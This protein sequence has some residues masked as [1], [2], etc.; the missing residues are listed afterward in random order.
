MD[1]KDF[2]PNKDDI[3]VALVLRGVTEDGSDKELFNADGTPMTITVM[4]PYSKDFKKAVSELSDKRIQEAAKKKKTKVSMAEAEEIVIETLA[5]TTRSWN[6]TWG[7]EK[8]D[9][10][11]DLAKTIYEDAFWIRNLVEDARDKTLDFMK[12]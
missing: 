10:N 6:I 11:V 2:T 12:A 7:G 9:F 3:E 1:L 8:P 4:S 5:V